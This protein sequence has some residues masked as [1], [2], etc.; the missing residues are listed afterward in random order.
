MVAHG[1]AGGAAPGANGTRASL[2]AA[3]L[4]ALAPITRLVSGDL[5]RVN[6]ELLD[7]L[8]PEQPDL[9]P[10]IDLAASYRGKQL[11]PALVFLCGRALGA[12]RDDHVEVA[13]I[14]E[15]L[16]TATLV[17]DDVLDGA[18]MRRRQQTVNAVYGT[19]VPVLLG[20][21]IYARAFHMSVQLRDPECS[22]V[23]AEVS[24]KLCQ[25]E[26][27]QIL[28]RFDFDWDEP[29]YYSVIREKT[30]LLYAAACRLGVHYAGG[31]AEQGAAAWR[32]GEELGIAF[33]IVDDILDLEGDESVVGKSLGTDL[34]KGKLTLPLLW[35][36]R[37]EGCRE[38]LEALMRS[39]ASEDLKLEALRREFPLGD[40]IRYSQAA[41][42]ARVESALDA[43]AGLPE[44]EPREAMRAL[45]QY[46]LDRKL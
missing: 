2:D 38:R 45:G 14:V 9:V 3:V 12:L 6:R 4:E 23:L 15:L 1:R 7:D 11:R 19:E 27:T 42:R 31:D 30:G 37:Q 22:R 8:A 26:I 18:T 46:V 16:H 34:G 21:F 10:L 44:G 28:H 17:H 32:F 36:L 33:Q 24:R 40:A 29:R 25:G 35:I 39:N 43:L 41:A 20:D 5:Q 13:K